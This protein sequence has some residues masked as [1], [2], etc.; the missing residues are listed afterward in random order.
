MLSRGVPFKSANSPDSCLLLAAWRRYGAFAEA[1]PLQIEKRSSWGL[2]LCSVGTNVLVDLR[3]NVWP[4]LSY[5]QNSPQKKLGI[6]LFPISFFFF[7]N[8]VFY[9]KV[10]EQDYPF[11]Y[12]NRQ[13]AGQDQLPSRLLKK[14]W[15]LDKEIHAC[16]ELLSFFIWTFIS[17]FL[18]L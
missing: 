17:T 2:S 16:L 7:N 4:L 15:L 9:I 10:S 11:E 13:L 3:I 14:L 6:Q 12:M 18:F 1:G 5:F 8:F